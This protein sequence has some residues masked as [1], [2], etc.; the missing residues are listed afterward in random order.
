MNKLIILIAVL[1]SYISFGQDC[2]LVGVDTSLTF[3]YEYSFRFLNLDD[4]TTMELVQ[5]A[6]DSSAYNFCGFT[7]DN[8]GAVQSGIQIIVRDKKDNKV[9]K[10]TSNA[11]GEF[12]LNL[13]PGDYKVRTA[14]CMHDRLEFE[15][16]IDTT[17]QQVLH[18]NLGLTQ[19]I[20]TYQ[21]NSKERLSE[22]K[23]EE[24]ME[25]VK[26]NREDVYGAC[27]EQGE[28]YLVVKG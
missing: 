21:I 6:K 26:V 11:K 20:I 25:C 27:S 13:P 8:S 3:S 17:H 5:T 9:I 16:G 14:S 28:Y 10:T 12:Q 15:V 23:I 24:L 22:E 2:K 4:S 1:S 7:K 19:E 18:V